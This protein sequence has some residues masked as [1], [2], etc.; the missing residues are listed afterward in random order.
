MFYYRPTVEYAYGD[1]IDLQEQV[2]EDL[3]KT[4]VEKTAKDA[5]LNAKKNAELAQKENQEKEKRTQ[6]CYSCRLS[7]IK[8]EPFIF[9]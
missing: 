5:A 2:K 8:S 6:T 7:L 4:K 3:A 1:I 9:S